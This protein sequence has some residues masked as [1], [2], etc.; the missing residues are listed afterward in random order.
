MSSRA[1]GSY[2]KTLDLLETKEIQKQKNKA[3][4]G[5]TSNEEEVE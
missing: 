5:F 4:N 3:Q 2:R 1:M